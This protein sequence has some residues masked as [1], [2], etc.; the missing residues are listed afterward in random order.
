[1]TKKKSDEQSNDTEVDFESAL[2]ELETLV[3]R[4][5]SGELSL[6]ESLKAFERGIELT[7][8]CQSS[9][10]AAE[11]RVQTLTKDKELED[12]DPKIDEQ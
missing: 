8:K 2:K 12:S 3:S 11:L 1:M 7:R 10:E 4:M 5:E 9:L 6:D